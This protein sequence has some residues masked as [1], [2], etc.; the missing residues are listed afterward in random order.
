MS[1]QGVP[2]SE[3]VHEETSRSIQLVAEWPEEAP[4][5]IPYANSFLVQHEAHRDEFY[6]TIGLVAPPMRLANSEIESLKKS[7]TIPIK[8]LI[9]VVL[10]GN[11]VVELIEALKANHPAFS[12]KVTGVEDHD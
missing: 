10:S 7:G 2:L 1:T 11:R 9:R 6:L 5:T 4:A 12:K 8:P 3:D